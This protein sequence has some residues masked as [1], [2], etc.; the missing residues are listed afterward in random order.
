M[1]VVY[2]SSFP[3]REC[4]IATFTADLTGAMDDLLE[5]VVESRIAAMNTDA[6]SR[7]HYPRQVLFQIDPYSE[8]DYL[9]TA[10][11]IN[12][13]DDVKLVNVQH[14][15]GLFGGGYGVNI[16][17]F[18]GA[19]KKPSVVTFHSV[20]PSPNSELHRVV[21]SIAEKA[22]GVTA[23]TNLSREILVREY[24]IDEKKI[25]V[26]PHGIHAA[27]YS[28]SAK[29]KAALGFSEKVS[30]LTFG[31]LSRG[32]GIEYVIEALPKVVKATPDLMY[33]VLGVTHPNVLKEEG[34]SY[35]NSLIQKVRDLGL[36]SH[37]S[38]YNEYASLDSLL[39]FLRAA[40]IY[41]STSLDPNQ[42]V[43]GTL[44][45]A[46]GSGRPVISTPFA[47]AREIIT[48][49]SGLLVNFKDPD[50]YA[51][52]I[53]ALLKDPV[54]REQFGKNA[55]FRTRN[56]TWENVALEYSKL[57]SEYSVELAEV[58]KHKKIPR[59]NLSHLFLLTDDFGIIQFSQLSL[60]DLASGYTVDDNARA[61][62]VA[63]L[64]Y[65]GKQK[66]LLKRAE[67]Y[68]R[69]IEYVLGEDGLFGN[70]VKSDRTIDSALNRDENLEDANG[71]TLWALAV[72]A[73]A[74]L[75]PDS[76][77]DKALSLFRKRIEKQEMFES[78]RASAF[79]AKGLCL[80]LKA[81]KRI[82]ENDLNGALILHCDRL[83]SLY[84]GVS[85]EEWPWF[86]NYLTYSNAVFPE[87]LLLGH[88]QTGNSEY[89]EIGT[90]TLDFLIRQTFINGIY[91]P[92][93]Q[94]GWHHKM[95][96]RRYFDQ[97][98][99]D[100][101]A[102]AC[103]LATAARVTGK[104]AYKERMYE[105]FNW[106]LGDNSLEQVVYDRATGGCYDGVGEGHINLNQGAESTTSYLLARLAVVA[107]LQE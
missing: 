30:L 57:F 66:N 71:R 42:A 19:L 24:G 80:L 102:M 88:Q 39:Q 16:L 78:P 97:Q 94:D 37:V 92:I 11:S 45:Y 84:R 18:L 8:R 25:S 50:S 74:E 52:A 105:A 56:M 58:S 43:S 106:F 62:I 82:G 32:K 59:I 104:A 41:I 26:I 35:R 86:E 55:Y 103:A 61:L 2:L 91:A 23:M 6:V 65:S 38:F 20:L 34:E 22:S 33:I 89:L 44:S 99:E 9:Q 17:S 63:C 75:L 46:L 3:P 54:R 14:E 72:A 79:Y 10:E 29:P 51:E 87:A 98:P 7:Y 83:V 107:D 13:M 76:L 12:G 81:K 48:P 60:P 68:L 69:F 27:P 53:T 93:G 31:F 67:I 95:G 47:Q 90:K 64:C 15:F 49:E 85:S 1:K 21:R 70:Y 36:S 5:S 40:D 96:E 77:R 4:G 28:S 73:T 101:S 100:A